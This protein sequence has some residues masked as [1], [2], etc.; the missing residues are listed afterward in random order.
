MAALFLLA[1]SAA[2]AQPYMY[3]MMNL[4]PDSDNSI[5]EVWNPGG[6]YPFEMWVW[7]WPGVYGMMCSEFSIC[8]PAIPPM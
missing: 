1:S 5:C 4:S 8:Y 3:G 2:F 7:C 6:F